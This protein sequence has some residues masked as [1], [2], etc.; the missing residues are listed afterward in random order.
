MNRRELIRAVAA[1]TAQDAKLVESVISG[2]TDVITA[3]VAKG[4]AVTVQGFAKFAKV[5]RAARM[6]R[7]PRTGEQIRIKAS[8][9]VRVS[10]MKAFKDTVM[11]PGQAPRL[12]RGVWPTSPDLLAKQAAAR[13]EAAATAR[14]ATRTATGTGRPAPKRTTAKKTTAKKTTAKRAP[15][16]R[17]PAKKT[18]TRPAA[19]KTTAKRAPAKKTTAKKT[20]ARRAPAKR[21]A[22]KK[23]ARR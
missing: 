18:A 3:V 11:S 1:Q 7:N 10:P 9:R 16:K 23:T 17:A 8:K 4:E 22:A 14:P 13:K 21:T 2:A 19:K 20:T 5:E 6:G 15:A 12:E